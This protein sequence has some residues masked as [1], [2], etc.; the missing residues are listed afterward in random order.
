LPEKTHGPIGS[1]RV[2]HDL[3]T[4]TT[5]TTMRI[6]MATSAEQP[7]KANKLQR[8]IKGVRRI[9]EIGK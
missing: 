3:A 2:E 6:L 1:Q 5:T 8:G 4:K 9:E 7:Q